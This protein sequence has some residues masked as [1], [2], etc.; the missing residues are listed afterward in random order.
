[1][2]VSLSCDESSRLISDRLDRT[3][4]RSERIALRCHLVLCRHCRRFGRNMHLLRNLLRHK[5]ERDLTTQDT[6]SGLTP[7]AQARI[8]KTPRPGPIRRNLT[9]SL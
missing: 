5:A 8:R 7:D 2:I 1:M 9:I 4:S 6:P 3:L